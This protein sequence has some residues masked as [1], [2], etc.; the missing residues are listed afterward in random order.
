MTKHDHI[1]FSD[2]RVDILAQQMLDAKSYAGYDVR[3]W[4]DMPEYMRHAIRLQ[5][6]RVLYL[7]DKQVKP[8][9]HDTGRRVKPVT[10]PPVRI[11][12]VDADDW[13][14]KFAARLRAS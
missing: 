6:A 13:R 8:T 5:A 4:A 7:Q 11:D 10:P 3:P 9:V 2:P 14:S 12:D 1:L